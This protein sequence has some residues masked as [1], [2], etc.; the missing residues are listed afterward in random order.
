MRTPDRV[1]VWRA[2]LYLTAHK[3]Q[4][5]RLKTSPHG[6][7]LFGQLRLEVAV[8]TK[9]NNNAIIFERTYHLSSTSSNSFIQLYVTLVLSPHLTAGHTEVQDD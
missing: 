7:I 8:S 6:L 2:P 4:L 5:I 9:M 1:E 3:P